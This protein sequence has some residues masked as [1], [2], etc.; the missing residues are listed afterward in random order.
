MKVEALKEWKNYGGNI[1]TYPLKIYTPESLEDIQQI[2]REAERLDVQVRAIGSGLSFSD[3]VKTNGFL[4]KPNGLERILPVDEDGTLQPAINKKK[5]C[6]LESGVTIKKLNKELQIKGLALRNM[7]GYDAQTFVGAMSTSTH[8]SGIELPPLPDM[9]K[10][11]EVV[12][13]EGKVLRVEPTNGITVPAAFKKKYATNTD[14][15]LI[16]DDNYFN[17]LIVGLGSIGV[18]YAVT[19]EVRSK[20]WLKEERRVA[21][22]KDIKKELEE[23]SILRNNRHVDIYM[24]AYGNNL[25]II[26]IRNEVT[27]PDIRT[28]DAMK[29]TIAEFFSSLPFIRFI[30]NILFIVFPNRSEKLL[31]GALRLLAD[32]NYTNHSFKVLNLGKANKIKSMST[33]IGFALD[34]NEYLTAVEEIIRISKE[35]SKI[36]KQY[37]TSPIS[38]RFVKASDA[39]MSPQYKRDTC[40]VEIIG[41]KGSK[42]Y[43]EV[44]E[45]IENKL[46]HYGGRMHLGQ[47]NTLNNNQAL[48]TTMF[49]KINQWKRVVQELNGPKNVFCNAFTKRFGI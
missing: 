8:G 31:E 42:G 25:G 30:L 5:L 13:A 4:L 15:N 35:R 9:V 38:L 1:T 32:G 46:Y 39:Y 22:W 45:A 43:F 23:G 18:I 14:Y 21:Y 36:G 48:L 17:A 3:V 19:I 2:I 44:L 47:L 28:I 16:Q 12:V 11:L 26:S 49:P 20:Y 33:E 40:M 37:L 29:R 10:S 34:K 7:G 24:S 41:L 27:E 6:Q